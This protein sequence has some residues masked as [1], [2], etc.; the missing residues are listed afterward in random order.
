MRCEKFQSLLNAYADGALTEGESLMVAE[1]LQNCRACQLRWQEVQK[2]NRLLDDAF[3][4]FHPLP[5]Q[6]LRQRIERTIFAQQLTSRRKVAARRPAA[7]F[8]V[9]VIGLIVIATSL[10]HQ[11]SPPSYVEHRE[12]KISESQTKIAKAE[13]LQKLPELTKKPV[14]TPKKQLT[15]SIGVVSKPPTMK[16]T[17]VSF[18]AKPKAKRQ[19]AHRR[20]AAKPFEGNEPTETEHSAKAVS[21]APETFPKTEP[22]TETI[23]ISVERVIPMNP[24]D[25]TPSMSIYRILDAPVGREVRVLPPQG[26]IAQPISVV[27]LPMPLPSRP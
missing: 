10:M 1:H 25:P 9:A 6:I 8:A 15:P 5:S 24:T 21:E 22:R 14:Q 17:L 2:L 27:E 16:R 11:S 13:A 3:S 7:I 12:K 23:L 20:V 19:G 26:A 4:N 18:A